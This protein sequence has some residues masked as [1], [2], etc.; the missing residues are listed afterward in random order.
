[1]EIEIGNVV[2]AV[3]KN[4]KNYEGILMKVCIGICEEE[5][6]QASIIL[7]EIRG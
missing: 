6:T 7:K 2:K 3:C 4:G 5:P 1:M